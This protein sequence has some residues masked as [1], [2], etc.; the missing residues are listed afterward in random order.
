[1]VIFFIVYFGQWLYRYRGKIKEERL[2]VEHQMNEV[3]E[4]EQFGGQAGTK[5]DEVVMMSHP[6][7]AQVKDMQ[8]R[9]DQ[10]QLALRE[11]EA[12]QKA[13]ATVVR[14]EHIN[15]LQVDRDA[16]LAAELERLKGGRLRNQS[17]QQR[18]PQA[19]Q[20]VSE[21][22]RGNIQRAAHAASQRRAHRHARPTRAHWHLA[23][24]ITVFLFV[25][26]A[27]VALC[28]CVSCAEV[29]RWRVVRPGGHGRDLFGQRLF[30]GP[31]RSARAPTSRR[32]RRSRSRRKRKEAA[33]AGA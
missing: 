31:T 6:W 4:M 17:Q 22:E 11:Q 26:R 9:L 13:E 29:E 28:F 3:K 16:Q 19:V 18:R 5:D 12:Q 7:V 32:R 1:V 14:L 15:E 8:A 33:A 24:L 30:R 2:A 10:T 23:A 25:S 20:M 21:A 27:R